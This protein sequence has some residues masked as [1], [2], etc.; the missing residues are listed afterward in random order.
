M[1][2]ALALLG[3]AVLATSCAKAAPPATS[4]A[5]APSS[6]TSTTSTTTTRPPGPQNEAF[7]LERPYNGE[8]LGGLPVVVR[9]SANT[10]EATFVAE[11]QTPAGDVLD[12][13]V[14]HA[15]A[16]TGTWG[17]FETALGQGLGVTGNEVVVLYEYSAKDGQ[18]I[19]VLKV[20]VVLG[21]PSVPA[22]QP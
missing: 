6:T 9:G 17:S 5:P 11:L 2:K 14:V 20:P 13:Q 21:S 22:T 4:V 7:R 12:H 3:L 19:H 16:G 1:R 18:P 10:F 8:E 15:S